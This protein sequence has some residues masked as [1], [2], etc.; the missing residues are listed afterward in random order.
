MPG[1]DE[2]QLFGGRSP[3]SVNAS[4]EDKERWRRTTVEYAKYLTALHAD[5]IYVGNDLNNLPGPVPAEKLLTEF[6]KFLVAKAGEEARPASAGTLPCVCK[7]LNLLL[8]R[9]DA[10]CLQGVNKVV[11]FSL[12]TFNNVREGGNY[13]AAED[14]S[15]PYYFNGA[16]QVLRRHVA[17]FHIAALIQGG[18]LKVDWNTLVYSPRPE[19]PVR[20]IV[21]HRS[22]PAACIWS[23]KGQ[24]VEGNTP[25]A[26]VE[27]LRDLYTKHDRNGKPPHTMGED[28]RVYLHV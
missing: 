19:L 12:G 23:G 6:M 2:A 25:A 22:E 9:P 26:G 28:A 8:G 5:D 18:Y 15:E 1:I 16:A 10:T 3:L 7:Q 14:P 13:P 24:P 17:A 20:K 27:A 11:C 21:T 4:N